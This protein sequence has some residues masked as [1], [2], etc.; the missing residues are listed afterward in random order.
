MADEKKGGKF[1]LEGQ[2]DGNGEQSENNSE[3]AK[4]RIRNPARYPQSRVF[5]HHRH[6]LHHRYSDTSWNNRSHFGKHEYQ[7]SS[8][9]KRH[10][11]KTRIM[12]P[13]LW[14]ALTEGLLNA[15]RTTTSFPDIRLGGAMIE[16]RVLVPDLAEKV[17]AV[18]SR[19]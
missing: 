3:H 17:D 10:Q 8:E 4:R 9:E 14:F 13:S 19:E 15:T 5:Q 11:Q 7:L 6:Y 18:R 16:R 12:F 1:R 2:V